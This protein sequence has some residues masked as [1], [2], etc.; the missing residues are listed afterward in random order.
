MRSASPIPRWPVIAAPTVGSGRSAL[1][2]V[3]FAWAEDELE[4][5]FERGAV[6]AYPD[7]ARLNGSW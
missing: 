7:Q 5:G 1:R 3:T 4:D 6:S 2:V